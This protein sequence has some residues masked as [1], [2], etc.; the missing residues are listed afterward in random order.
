MLGLFERALVWPVSLALL[1]SAFL[2][3]TSHDGYS[4]LISWRPFADGHINQLG[5]PRFETFCI[6]WPVNDRSGFWPIEL[7]ARRRQ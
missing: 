3:E 5:D 6:I 2:D 1:P 4:Q 7:I